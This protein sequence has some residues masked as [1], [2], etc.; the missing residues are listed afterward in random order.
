MV[1]RKSR[2]AEATGEIDIEKLISMAVSTGKTK[3]AGKTALK[4]S[5]GSKAKAFVIAENC[6]DEFKVGITYN[7]KF[8]SVPIISYNK[9]SVELGAAIGRQHK[10]A[11]LT[12]FD[13]GN[14]KILD[15]IKKET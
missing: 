6:P 10:V 3:L 7:A 8:S 12:I 15:T 1:K 2:D 4:E 11:C 5:K 13:P 14:S 9:S